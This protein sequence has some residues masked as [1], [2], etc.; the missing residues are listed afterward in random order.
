[1]P[2]NRSTYG[3]F[4]LLV[5]S[6][7]EGLTNSWRVLRSLHRCQLHPSHP[8][9]KPEVMKHVNLPCLLVPFCTRSL[10]QLHPFLERSAPHLVAEEA[11]KGGSTCLATCPTVASTVFWVTSAVPDAIFLILSCRQIPHGLACAYL[12]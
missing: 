4:L 11:S 9:N 10:I 12:T 1:M 2:C 6:L 7:Q 5:L 3:F 8:G